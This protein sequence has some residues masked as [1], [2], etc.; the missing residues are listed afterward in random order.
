[1]RTLSSPKLGLLA[2]VTMMLCL[3][4]QGVGKPLPDVSG[5]VPP[6]TASADQ[7]KPQSVV[8][9]KEEWL[10]AD[11]AESGF[12][13]E[14]LALITEKMREAKG[15]GVLI[16]NGYLVAEW[17]FGAA[18]DKRYD[19][20]S[21]T[22][23]ITSFAVGLALGDGR[24]PSVDTPVQQCWP[25]YKAGPFTDQ[26]TFRHLMNMTAGIIQTTKYGT[27]QDRKQPPAYTEPGTCYNYLNDQAKAVATA[28][29]YIYG[30]ELGECMNEKLRPLGISM[31][32]G[33]EPRWDPAVTTAD[34]K[35]MRVN[36]GYSRARFA[37]A[38]LARIGHL[39]LQKGVWDGQTIVSPDF[40][41]QSLTAGP[42][43][44][45]EPREVGDN[46]LILTGGYGFAWRQHEYNGVLTWGMHGYG[47]QFC[48]I[49]PQYNV[50]MTKLSAWQD[51]STWIGN[52]TFYPLLIQ[53][54]Q[55]RS[56]YE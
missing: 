7:A 44:T 47:H 9:P 17:N 5:T 54:L 21:C 38:D 26:I 6:V 37:A 16:R 19:T 50:V 49:I 12:D 25:D 45:N 32:W 11:A 18:A 56:G 28:L 1:M 14:T 27:S 30:R 3:Q 35:E 24:I 29:T 34:G 43:S 51:Q 15:N 55:K 10:R 36:C 22:K 2:G 53:A 40:V 4:E 23:S 13:L 52:T 39:Y 31:E 42:I 20:Q 41:A 8:F 33:S 48:V 46:G